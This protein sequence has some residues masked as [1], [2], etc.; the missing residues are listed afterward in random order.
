M[1][2]SA[3]VEEMCICVDCRWVDRCQTYHAVERQ[4]GV[5]HL[6]ATPDIEPIDPRI[7]ISVLSEGNEGAA[8]EWDVR[9]CKTFRK[10]EGR[11][12]RLSPGKEIPR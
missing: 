3:E 6:T 4:H 5:A 2:E 12:L 1:V 8:V 9:A 10:D 11:W 7:H